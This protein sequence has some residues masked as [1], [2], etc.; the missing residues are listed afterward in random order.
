MMKLVLLRHGESE[1]NK[2]NLFTG[3]MDVDLSDK[4]RELPL[5]LPLQPMPGSCSSM[6]LHQDWISHIWKKSEDY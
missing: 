1:W 5:H 2:L 3:W 6:S 4:G